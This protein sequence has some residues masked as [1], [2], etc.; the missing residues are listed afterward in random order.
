[1][2][3][4]VS[5]VCRN[6]QLLSRIM[7]PAWFNIPKYTVYLCIYVRSMYRSVVNVHR[8]QIFQVILRG[9]SYLKH[10]RCIHEDDLRVEARLFDNLESRLSLIMI[11]WDSMQQPG[12]EHTGTRP[13]SVAGRAW[14]T[15]LSKSSRA[16]R[17][18]HKPHGTCHR[19]KASSSESCVGY[20]DS[21]IAGMPGCWPGSSRIP[22]HEN[23]RRLENRVVINYD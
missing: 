6:E 5:A 14:R 1:M 23:T 2:D 16:S 18:R 21:A 7:Q 9:A 10:T 13:K 12:P 11:I 3:R 19:N 4:G 8:G 22:N 17:T 20:P 15:L